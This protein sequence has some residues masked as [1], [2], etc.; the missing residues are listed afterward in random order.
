MTIRTVAI[1]WISAIVLSVLALVLRQSERD[2]N[3]TDMRAATQLP[4]LTAL[5]AIDLSRSDGHWRFERDDTGVWWQRTPF[6]HRMDASRLMAIPE[7]VQ[8]MKAVA[9]VPLDASQA[10]LL[11]LSLPDGGR[12]L[13]LL[14]LEGEDGSATEVHLGR[15]GVG[16]RGWIR[17]D[18]SPEAMVVDDDLHTMVLQ[19]A[20][21][22]WRDG[23]L[24]HGANADADSINWS[25]AGE[26]IQLKRS[27]RR[28]AFE[29][30]LS[31][32]ADADAVAALLGV[33]ASAR[34]SSVLLDAPTNIEAFGLEPPMARIE[35]GQLGGDSVALRIGDRLGGA[36]GDR[37]AMIEGVPSVVRVDQETVATLLDDPVE[38]VDRT[39]SGAS[40][41][42]VRAIRVLRDDGT[43]RLERTL[44]TWSFED[45]SPA[46]TMAVVRLL[47]T[48]TSLQ[49]TEVSLVET[50]PDELEQA[51]VVFEGT[52]GRPIDTVRV[53]QEPM[54]PQS[55][56]RWGLE[57]GDGVIRILP[58][59]TWLGLERAHLAQ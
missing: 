57:N 28:W 30:P 31:T 6:E 55:G 41:I 50:Y 1:L 39:G 7:L 3:S 47:E 15:T 23:R 59:G 54:T 10:S 13:A 42:D 19:E 37:Y 29:S 52:D 49:G 5:N 40:P 26:N 11:G 53:L 45:G 56:G 18:D 51:V 48:L 36:T 46:D 34:S 33:A 24:L 43:L 20:P 21:R 9:R 2:T 4:S 12:D 27:G 8:V 25:L 38:L 35:I 22:N 58:A 32:R 14:R 44:D 17:I 16:G